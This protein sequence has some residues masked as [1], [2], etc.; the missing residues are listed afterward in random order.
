MSTDQCIL[1]KTGTRFL[2]GNFST[3]EDVIDYMTC[4][5]ERADKRNDD[6][7]ET[8][9]NTQIEGHSKRLE[10]LET[11]LNT[12][13]AGYSNVVK[14]LRDTSDEIRKRFD[15]IEGENGN[16]KNVLSRLSKETV[17]NATGIQD[18]KSRLSSQESEIS[19]ANSVLSRLSKETVSNATDI[20][21][22]KSSLS[23]VDDRLSKEMG[24]NVSDIRDLKRKTVS[25]AKDIHDLKS[26]LSTQEKSRF[27]SSKLDELT[28]LAKGYTLR[29]SGR[30]TG[31]EMI[32]SIEECQTAARL[33]Q[34]KVGS[35]NVRTPSERE[36]TRF[37]P[38]ALSCLRMKEDLYWFNND[39]RR[40]RDCSEK[41]PCVV[42]NTL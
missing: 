20:R 1:E 21:E 3:Q 33:M 38:H 34:T 5:I 19:S 41:F 11:M 30:Q 24:S 37:Q 26:R 35:I 12:Q 23:S 8:M 27:S 31:E 36:K 28:R 14:K 7:L 9:L 25:N 4:T 6:G 32:Q 2:R 16:N 13:I 15:I 22:V 17:N 40:G 42:R 29:T 18:M 10:G 39:R